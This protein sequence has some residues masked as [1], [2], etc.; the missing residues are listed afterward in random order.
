MIEKAIEFAAIKHYNQFRKGSSIP[1]I[2]Y[3]MEVM[4]VLTANGLDNK[5]IIAGILHDTIEDTNTTYEEIKETFGVDIA[6]MVAAESEDKSK[7]WKQRKQTTID[8]LPK[9]SKEVQAICCA[10]KMS[11]LRDIYN[12]LNNDEIGEKVWD[13]FNAPKDEIEWYY[14]SIIENLTLVKEYEMYKDLKKYYKL[15]F[16]K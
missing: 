16:K 14:K 11:N 8:R 5:T 10:D 12:E 6:D 4:Q 1:Y 2:V 7:S 3:P 9:E 13:K 15:V